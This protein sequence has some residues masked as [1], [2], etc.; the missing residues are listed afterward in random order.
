[1]KY[2]NCIISLRWKYVYFYYKVG[3]YNMESVEMDMIL[4]P[5]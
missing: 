5:N 4:E 3:C 1:M 2:M